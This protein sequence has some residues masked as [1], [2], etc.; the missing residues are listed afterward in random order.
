VKNVFIISLALLLISGLILGSCAEP[1]PTP[2]P[3]P[4]PTP[5]TPTPAQE[6]YLIRFSDES[7]PAQLLPQALQELQ[8]KIPQATNGRVKFEYY[9]AGTL[10]NNQD[11]MTALKNGTLEMAMGGAFIGWLYKEWETIT[12]MP[13]L[14]DN[15]DQLLR[16]WKTSTY[17]D[18]VARMTA[19]GIKPLGLCYPS[20]LKD[21]GGF[22]FQNVKPVKTL[23]DFKGIRVSFYPL[24][25][26]KVLLEAAGLN[27]T[28]V[29]ITEL[30]TAITT[31]I[32]DGT[33]AGN[34]MMA[35]MPNIDKYLPYCTPLKA[36]VG[37]LGVV[38]STKFWNTLPTDLQTILEAVFEECLQGWDKSNDT[39]LTALLEEWKAKPGCEVTELSDA[40]MA[41]V[42][43]IAKDAFKDLD[44]LKD[45]NVQAII[46]AADS[47]R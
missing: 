37:L 17:K 13:Y 33:Y 30:T 45:P 42:K 15:Y 34:D 47:V 21:G 35:N 22:I 39:K 27:P 8:T 26:N 14:F 10:Y 2:A 36:N 7:S 32:V 9:G 40:D 41:T 5:A 1:A 44:A 24:E 38:I 6:Q 12:Y 16:F 28:P 25:Y 3:A 4:T 46:K 11:A 29:P 19:D 23:G 18:L 31:G 20:W 43:Q